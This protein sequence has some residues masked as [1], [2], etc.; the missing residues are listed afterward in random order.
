MPDNR[1]YSRIIIKLKEGTPASAL[2]RLAPPQDAQR[3]RAL[4][5][6]AISGPA[7]SL[8]YLKTIHGDTHV[9]VASAALPRSEL[10]A[11]AANLAQNPEVE[12]AEVDDFIRPHAVP[13][14]PFFASSLWNLKSA[15]S[16]VGGAN[17][18]NAWDRMQSG[19]AVNGNN[20]VI[21]VLD[22][23]YRP[24]TDLA[25]NLVGG[26]DFVSASADRDSTSGWDADPLD[27]G[28]WST[29]NTDCSTSSWHG[30][31]VAGIAGAVGNNSYGII[32]GA[33]GGKI[34]P[35]RVL[36]I[37]GGWSSDIQ[38]GMYWAAGLRTAG[39]SLNPHV[40]K[41]INLS[42]GSD[43]GV[44]CTASYQTAVD[45]V[46]NA[47]ITLVASTGND[48]SSTAIASPANCSGVIAVTAHRSDG[49]KPAYANTGAGT[50]LSAP[51]ASIY[52]TSNT[53]GTLPVA[54]PGGD[55]FVVANGTSMAAPHVAAAAALLYQVNPGISPALVRS[56]L[57]TTARPF[58]NSS[59]CYNNSNCGT[60][61]LD[62]FAAV[63][64]LQLMSAGS[65]TAPVLNP[66]AAQSATNAG[67]LQFSAVA[68]D[69]DSDPLSYTI[70]PLPS[71]A[72]FNNG[73]GVFVWPNPAPGSYTVT[74]RAS[75]G[76]A[77]SN[78]QTVAIAVSTAPASG[79]GGGGGALSWWEMLLLGG[80]LV[81]RRWKA[82]AAKQ[83]CNQRT[84]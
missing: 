22:T 60:G 84:A 38:E 35:V 17:F 26:Y 68:S 79:S 21:A 15:S 33:Y 80:A 19:V 39:G 78:S 62:A 56:L 75:D 58:P 51:G 47:G 31:H 46:I 20:T 24:H 59:S 40:A 42:L 9:A 71:G 44:A 76:L 18:T 57:T 13:N 10:Q 83:E 66:I 70:T 41:V 37:C 54:S 27:P 55:S 43:A 25:S 1:L 61:M 63:K 14:D 67:T 72:S 82:S 48:G 36:G 28:D 29:T 34:L 2:T 69:A 6:P 30:T 73:T 23:G 49:S 32:G 64:K 52:S 5:A 11:V 12:F 4:R 3:I 8:D 81:A 50:A 16:A 74:V 7:V 65:N 53:G 45:A 77:T